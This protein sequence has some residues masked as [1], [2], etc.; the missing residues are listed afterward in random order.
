[1]EELRPARRSSGLHEADYGSIH[2]LGSEASLRAATNRHAFL[3]NAVGPAG[4][5]FSEGAEPFARSTA[6]GVVPAAAVKGAGGGD[7]VEAVSPWEQPSAA[8]PIPFY[9]KRWFIISQLIIIPLGIIL[10]FVLLFPVVRAI[11]QLVIKRSQLDIEVATISEPQNNTFVTHTGIISATIEFLDPVDVSWIEDDDTETPIG[12]MVLSKLSARSKHKRA[13]IN[14]NTT[15]TITDEA[16]FGRFSGHLITAQNFTWRLK[17]SNLRVQA[18][19]FPVA[20]GLSFDKKLTLNGFNSFDGNVVL[21]DLQLPSD[22]PAGGI[23]FKAVTTLVNKRHVFSFRNRRAKADGPGSPFSLNLG[24]VIFALSYLNV[25]LGLGRGVNTVINPGS[26]DITLEGYLERKTKP[27][28]LAALSQLFTNYLNGESS[29]VVATGQ[30]T[31]Q[32][33]NSTI[34]WLSQGLQSLKLDVPFKA[35]TA[36]DPIRSVTI[37]N[38]G[39]QFNEKSPWT[40]DAESDSVQATLQL[41]FGFNLAIDQIQNEFTIVT[42]DGENVAG[43]STPLGASKSSITVLGPDNTE[44]TINISIKD[45]KLS[46]PDPQHPAFS[47]FNANLTSLDSAEFRLIGRSRAVANMSIGQITLDPI[48]FNVS[49]TLNGLKGLKGLTTIDAVDVQGGSRDGINLG[50]DVSIFNPSNLDLSTGDLNLQL[51]RDGVALGTAL[52]PNLTLVRGNNSFRATSS[53]EAN[54]SPQG[55]QTLNDFVGKKDVQLQIAGYDGST[56]VVSLT[57]AFK[58]LNIDATLPGL[59]TSLLDT[60]ALTVLST[61]GRENNIS[62]VTVSLNNPFSTPLHITRITS[63]VRSYGIPLGTIET[64]TDFTTAPKATTRS[65]NLDLKLNFD[66]AALF[67]LT[68]ALAVEAGLDVDPLDGIVELGGIKYLSITGEPPKLKRRANVF[69]GFNLPTFVQTAFK[70]LKSDV[71]LTADVTIGEYKTTLQ[72]TQTGLPTGTDDSLNFILP[73]LA[74]PIVQQI[75]GGSSL[76]ISNVLITDPKQTSFGTKLK[77]NIGNAG[78]FDA[79]ISFP[80]GLT[81]GWSGKALGS[82]KMDDVSVIGDVG[83]AIDASSS[84]QVADVAHLTSFTKVLL[85]ESSFDWD[86]S[87]ENLTVSAL[88]IRVPGIALSSKRVT[89]KGFNGLKGGVKIKTFDL[90]S[91]DPAGGIHLTLEAATS[92]PSQV[93]I[94]LSSIGF[95]TYVGNVLIAPVL[96]AGAVTL[97]PG[98][99][100]DLSLVGRLIPQ[101]SPDGLSTVSDI[102]NNFVHGKDSNVEV[103]GASAGSKEVTW[104]NE[105]IKSLRIATVL[106]NRGAL[107]IIKS[108]NLNQL[109][110]LFTEKTAYNPSTSSRSTDA[111]FTLPFGFPLDITSLEQTLTIGYEGTSFAQLALPKAPS[112]TDVQ[113]RIIH[114]TFDNV[115]F[116]VFGDKHSTFDKFVA[117]TTVGKTQ[118]LRLS[119]SANAEAKTAVGLLSL[120]GIDFSVDSS[121]DGLQGLN[122]KPVLVRNVDV[123]HG[124]PDYLLIKVDSNLFNPSNLTIGTGDVAFSLQYQS[125]TIGLAQLNN[126]VIKPGNGNYS[127]DVRYAPQGEAVSAGRSL[128]QNFLQGIDADTTIVGTTGST[129]ISS[130]KSALSQIRLSP[131]SI[132]ALHDTLIKSASLRFP[133]DIVKTGVAGT[134]FTLANPFTASINLLKLGATATYHGIVLGKINNIDASSH[135]IHADGHSSVTS[136]TLPLEFN[137]QPLAI[138]QLLTVQSQLNNVNLGP[139]TQLFQFVVE[140]PGFKPPVSTELLKITYCSMLLQVVTSVDTR[141]PTCVSGRQFDAAGAIL[142]TLANLKVDLAVE[143]SVKLDDFATDLAFDQKG[144]PAITDQ[145]ALFLIGAVAGPVA[146]ALV[147]GSILKFS[148]ANITNIS[149]SG[150]DL[151]LVGSLTNIGP[152]DASIDFTE[153]LTVTWQGKDIATIALPPICAAAGSGVPDYRTKARLT[154]TEPSEFTTF[155]TFLLHNPSFDWTISSKKLRLTALGTI[156]ENVALSKVVSFKAFNGLP[157]V[158]ISNFQLPSDDPAGGIHIETDALIPSPAQLGIDLGTVTFQSFFQ[159]TLVGPLSGKNLFLAANSQ[160]NSH[161]SGRIQPQ[162]GKDLENLGVLFSKFLAGENQTLV[163]KGESVQPDGSSGP[164]TWLSTAFKT[165]ELEVTLPGQKFDVIQ[166]IAL[167]DLSVTIEKPE[168]AFAPPASSNYTLAKYKNPFGFSLQV[169]EAG[170]NLILD[171]HGTDI[172]QLTLPKIPAVG[173]VSTGNVA[174]LVIAFRDVPLRALNPA[175]F[176]QMLAGVTL[177]GDLDLTLKGAADVTAKTSIGNVQLSGIPFNVASSLKG[178]NSFGHTASL[179]N[180][181]VTGSGGAGGSEYIISPLTT[182]LQNPSNISLNTLGISLPVIYQGTKIGRAVIDP[183]HLTPGSNPSA[184]E[185]HYQPDNANDTI[186]QAFLSRFIQ[187]GDTLDLAIRGDAKSSPFPSLSP[188]L[189]QLQLR[190]SL[191][192]LKQ[193]DFITHITVTITLETLENDLVTVNFDVHNP[194]DTELALEFVQSDA[195]VNGLTYAAFGQGF[196]SFVVPAGAT[197]NSGDIPNVLLT[198][199]AIPSLDIIPLQYL[200]VSA[201]ATVRVG[202][203]GGYEVPWLKLSQEKVPTE[204][205]LVLGLTQLREKAEELRANGTSSAGVESSTTAS[206]SATSEPLS[207]SATASEESKPESSAGGPEPSAAAPAPTK[208]SVEAPPKS[209][210]SSPADAKPEASPAPAPAPAPPE[211][212]AAVADSSSQS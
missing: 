18:L 28:D 150:F 130:L 202:G 4:S 192:G 153:P 121:V 164:V 88:G 175:A 85:T 103:R 182:V 50:I 117:A 136:P 208:P 206:V 155:A 143:T 69:T 59:K 165:L 77:G 211:A 195:G 83:G 1:M 170:Q 97:A 169:I 24:T 137:L 46:C 183:F 212:T 72:Y 40:P 209:E 45:T 20:K 51:F 194:L 190:T 141:P 135:P 96:S 78:P 93:G 65:P 66:P 38:L 13:V 16:A 34:S 11:A 17:S 54:Q 147:D 101:N 171:S 71:E 55:L 156:F 157:G 21:K 70:K 10:L 25:P 15:F 148:E 111:A 193:P 37:G 91:N 105:G 12:T 60:A 115:P 42:N 196:P 161:L 149:D 92:N 89:L 43:L 120:K 112:R 57:E 125:Q 81:V 189:S 94:S 27:S 86:I 62:H 58:T 102:F 127:I 49:T 177:L 114:L 172:A 174:D 35:F 8:A 106:P 176:A 205:N 140:H 129:P 36:I 186:A 9:K 198:Q 74:Q 31:L 152:L 104:L 99:T 61:T 39:L 151:S 160:T 187:T 95:E 158:T 203:K 113:N 145:T 162:S 90:P 87:G 197:V 100:T 201:A 67:T 131:V 126:L 7:G 128:L 166:S 191:T 26:N 6:A 76:G 132:P 19:K 79:V 116:A 122:T 210:A 82:I 29:P 144:V 84:F 3:G 133:L 118:T 107:N 73:V 199:G 47:K 108:I 142:K 48:K 139:L 163:T 180:V 178:I 68:R 124:Y 2:S 109:Q 75:V 22:N 200:D 119:G 146:Q 204:Y 44:G 167:N 184:T 207:T 53:F 173:G 63:T 41:P 138:I 56:K 181:S 14:D 80:A 32:N 188:G 52:L 64:N 23:N 110:L 123:A 179:S 30:S 159:G 154:I 33:D 185:F 98:A 168:H 134:S 5:R